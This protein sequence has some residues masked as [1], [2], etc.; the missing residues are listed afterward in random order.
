[1]KNQPHHT[2]VG[3]DIAK[4]HLD[5]ANNDTNDVHRFA[6]HEEG[7]RSLKKYL[8]QRKPQRVVMEAT[9][10]LERRLLHDLIHAGFDVAIVNPRQ[11]RDYARAFN[12]L[13][14]TD[15]IDA[16][17]IASFAAVVQPK[18]QELPEKTEEKLQSLIT[19]RRQ[20]IANRVRESNR[21][22]RT[23]DSEV[24]AMI[25]DA[26]AFYTKQLEVL[27]AQIENI[28]ASNEPLRHRAELLRST[29]G[30][31]PAAAAALVAELPE[32][33]R[34]NRQE[35]AKLVGVAPLNRDSGQMRGKRTI[36]GGR[37][38][39]RN[40]LYMPTIVATRFNATI[41]MYYQRLLAQ[42]KQRMVALVAAMRKLLVILN[43]M[44]R[45]DQ[46]WRNPQNA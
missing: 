38:T 36:A 16:R 17:M 20:A 3:I 37:T 32:L 41:R 28:I 11:I 7:L 29:P 33:G 2:F 21:L 13:A 4:R 39:V 9:G 5:V 12:K 19:R 6:Y 23:H 31:G 35:I 43:I 40:A 34:L 15:A 14:K 46:P 27:N 44:I 25:E 1:M 18:S 26:V 24:R 45:D 22:E 42:G 30:I 10:G 8:R